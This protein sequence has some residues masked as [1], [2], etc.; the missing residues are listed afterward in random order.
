MEPGA[1]CVLTPFLVVLPPESMY[2]GLPVGR[3]TY[4]IYL[5]SNIPGLLEIDKTTRNYKFNIPPW[6][7]VGFNVQGGILY[8]YNDYL[9]VDDLFAYFHRVSP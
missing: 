9:C 6:L 4:F 1:M 8:P 7:L 3:L 2:Q 5:I